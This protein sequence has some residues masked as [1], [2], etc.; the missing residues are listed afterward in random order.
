MTTKSC[1]GA[2]QQYQECRSYKYNVKDK[3]CALSRES[4]MTNN[5]IPSNSSWVVRMVYAGHPI[6]D[7][8]PLRDI[9]GIMRSRNTTTYKSEITYTCPGGG[10]SKLR[11]EEDNKWVPIVSS[12]K[13]SDYVKIN[14]GRPK[15]VLGA[16]SSY[17]TT[18]FKSVVSYT[19]PKGEQQKST[20]EWK[21]KWTPVV[22]TCR[23]SE[24]HFVKVEKAILNVTTKTLLKAHATLEA[25]AKK[26]LSSKVCLSFEMNKQKGECYLSQET[27]A[28]SKK[29]MPSTHTDYYQR[30]EA[31]K[32]FN[33][34]RVNIPQKN[35]ITTLQFQTVSK[36]DEACR[37]HQGCNSYEYNEE[38][39]FCILSDVTPLTGEL[40]PNK[41]RWDLYMIYPVFSVINCGPPKEVSGAVKSFKTITFKS[42]VIYTCPKGEQLRSI[43]QMNSRWST[44]VSSCKETE[45]YFVKVNDATLDV[46]E[47][48]LLKEENM[49]AETCAHKCLLDKTC[50][51]FEIV[52][53]EGKCYLSK[54]SAAV[55]KKLKTTR[56]RDYYQRVNPSDKP[57]VIKKANIPDKYTFGRFK[58]KTLEECSQACQQHHG[59]NSYEYNEK[60][61]ICALS[62][63][64]QTTEE[65]KPDSGNWGTYVINSVRRKIDC[66]PPI[67]VAGASKSYTSTTFKSKV[68]YTCPRREKF[69][70]KCKKNSK[71]TQVPSV[72]KVYRNI[73]CGPPKDIGGASKFFNTTTYQ[74]KVIYICPKGDKLK[75]TCNK[76]NKWTAVVS[77][78]KDIP[79]NFVKISSSFLDVSGKMLWNKKNV[80]VEACADKCLSYK[81]CLSFEVTKKGGKCY[82]LQGS[83][84][85]STEIKTSNTRDYYQRVKPEDKPSTADDQP[86][87]DENV[88]R[89][90]QTCLNYVGCR[91]FEYSEKMNACHLSNVTRLTYKIKL[92]SI[93]GSNAKPDYTKVDCG[94]P[95]DVV[96]ASKSYNTTTYKSVVTYTCPKGEKLNST[97]DKDHKWTPVAST[98]K[99]S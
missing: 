72:C 69:K 76:K 77:D 90:Y 98:C 48:T 95:K 55:H 42:I 11:C 34:R 84:V 97:C 21:N 1:D 35:T 65:L 30:V 62:N 58:D 28:F 93:S 40:K 44:V 74:S 63:V 52:K 49:T 45:I 19:C 2:C 61:K 70:S 31:D 60:D 78:C 9:P 50:L 33:L 96:G 73:N 20:C 82:L 46:P 4:H 22:A 85:S 25:C 81:N 3:L 6:V 64:T 41:A 39:K 10:I 26:C 86:P 47:K 88:K 29:L 24:I 23:D 89:C 80:T 99:E 15:K 32:P 37:K 14:C 83:A 38:T 87:M 36:C 17:T 57:V 66:G 18:N 8:G 54:T 51:S 7:C 16:L 67:D 75:A 91:S 71:W 13:V 53:T 56:L 94:P 59:C 68:T 43:C 12:C 79:A 27:A 92:D 5:I